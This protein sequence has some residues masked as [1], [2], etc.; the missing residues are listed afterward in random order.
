MIGSERALIIDASTDMLLVMA[1]ESTTGGKISVR[2]GVDRLRTAASP[3]LV[4]PRP[5]V[6]D[7]SAA[8][9]P[10]F[11]PRSAAGNSAG[12]TRRISPCSS[13]WPTRAIQNPD[14][15]IKSRAVSA[16]ELIANCTQANVWWKEGVVQPHIVATM[17]FSNWLKLPNPDRILF[18]ARRRHPGGAPRSVHVDAAAAVVARARP[19]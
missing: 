10:R 2:V 16:T 6:D 4:K 5:P 11:L 7:V 15:A 17:S 9:A 18:L 3:F 19:S 1:G 12:P 8:G 13:S 14:E